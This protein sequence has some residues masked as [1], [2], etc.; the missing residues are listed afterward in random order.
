M[1]RSHGELPVTRPRAGGGRWLGACA[2][3]MLFCSSYAVLDV[4]IW[5]GLS[6][7]YVSNRGDVSKRM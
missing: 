7:M 2:R 5:I 4:S 3:E 6:G 1:C